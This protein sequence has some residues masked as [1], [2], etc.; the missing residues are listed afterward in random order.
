MPQKTTSRDK[1]NDNGDTD[2]KPNKMTSWDHSPLSLRAFLLDIKANLDSMDTNHMNFLTGH[3]IT[4]ERSGKT[5]VMSAQQAVA[6]DNDKIS[7][8]GFSLGH[9]ALGVTSSAPRTRC[10]TASKTRT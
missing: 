1:L 5:S 8:L 6:I 3:Y 9:H 10:L 2:T 7:D 4:N